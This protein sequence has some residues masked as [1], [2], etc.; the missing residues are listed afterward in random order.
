MAGIKARSSPPGTRNP[1]RHGLY[2][3]KSL[4]DGDGLDKR[5]SYPSHSWQRKMSWPLPSVKISHLSDT[6][7]EYGGPMWTAARQSLRFSG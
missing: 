5:S 7:K 6:G 2:S 4:V 1:M 3:L